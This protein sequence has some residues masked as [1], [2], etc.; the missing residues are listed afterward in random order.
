MCGIIMFMI[1]IDWFFL[2]IKKT[3]QEQPIEQNKNTIQKKLE[4][5]KFVEM[6][7]AKCKELSQPKA[8]DRDIKIEEEKC[9]TST[10]QSHI[11]KASDDKMENLT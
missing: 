5:P 6:Q 11:R 3:P 2:D 7:E 8:E 10:S 4:K 9:N 1:A